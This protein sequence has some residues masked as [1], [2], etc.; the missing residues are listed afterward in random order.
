MRRF[1]CECGQPLFFENSSCLACGAVT[2]FAPA[3]RDLLALAPAA[4]EQWREAGGGDATWRLC[5]NRDACAC[6]WLLAEPEPGA[7]CAACASTRTL[8]QLTTPANSRRWRELETAKRRLLF[9]LIDLEL[10]GPGSPLRPALP[11]VF[12]FKEALPGQDPVTTGHEN[13]VITIDAAEAD[14]D[15]RERLRASLNEP[16]RTLL[17]HL[18]HETGHY[19]WDLLI[20]DSPLLEECRALFGDDTQDYAA[21]LE[22]HYQAGPPAGW[23]ENHISSYAT[24]HPWED[25]AETW[26]HYLHMTDTLETAEAA[27]LSCGPDEARPPPADDALFQ[28]IAGAGPD[29]AAAFAGKINRWHAVVVLANELSRSMGQPDAYPFS[30]SGQ[31]ARKLFFVERAILSARQPDS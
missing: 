18:R 9:T 2:G 10:W 6:N 21:A 11:L 24:M 3:R 23:Q 13:G 17:G 29:E 25:W 28:G 7:F 30:L 15:H 5:A 19:Y 4:P 22:R 31:V 1:H 27:L 20:R 16:Y 8:P 12:D 26:A 14:D